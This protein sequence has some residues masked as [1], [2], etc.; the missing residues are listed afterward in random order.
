[1]VVNESMANSVWP[2][3]SALGKCVMLETASA[4]CT[5]VIGVVS[6]A[7]LG[8]LL[9][10]APMHYY[11]PMAQAFAGANPDVVV[12]TTRF[13]T[14]TV[15]AGTATRAGL[16][17]L[18]RRDLQGRL[19]ASANIKVGDLEQDLVSY[20]R[21]WREGAVLFSMLGALA[22][23]VTT[24]GVYSVTAYMV[25]RRTHEMGVRIAL[26]AKSGD[27]VRLVVGEGLS[28]VVIGVVVGAGIALALGKL[29]GSLLYGVSPHDPAVVAGASLGFMLIAVA[30]CLVPARRA[31]RVDP[32][33]AL[34]AE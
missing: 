11:I 4:P 23:L 31:M 3:R 22:L 26:G 15:R 19:P 16:A 32:V 9:E 5:T 28:V 30:A 2:G 6:D 8:D 24:V 33:E 7:H 18:I 12:R 1:M 20:Y 27:I 25:A 14:I 21:Q 17:Q 29:V 10:R 34:R 13:A